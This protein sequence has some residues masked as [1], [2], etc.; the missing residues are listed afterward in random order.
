MRNNQINLELINYF[1]QQSINSS[2]LLFSA[3][4]RGNLKTVREILNNPYIDPN[5]QEV[6]DNIYYTP[7]IIA[8]QIGYLE[9]VKEL[10]KHPKIKQIK[11]KNCA[12][13]IVHACAQG[14]LEVVKE[15]LRHHDHEVTMGKYAEGTK[16]KYIYDIHHLSFALEA[17]V[18][19]NNPKNKKL[20]IAKQ[21]LKNPN[22]ELDLHTTDILFFACYQKDIEMVKE[23]LKQPEINPNW[24][25]SPIP[26][27]NP[28]LRAIDDNNLEI[29]KELLKH[30][31]INPNYS[32]DAYTPLIHAINDNNLEIV[33]EL[34]KHPKINPNWS[35]TVYTPLTHAIKDNNLVI[36]KELLKHPKINVNNVNIEKYA[37]LN[38]S[39]RKYIISYY[40]NDNKK[41]INTECKIIKE[42]LPYSNIIANNKILELLLK[43]ILTKHVIEDNND[44]NDLKSLAIYVAKYLINHKCTTIPPDLLLNVTDPNQKIKEKIK[45][46]IFKTKQEKQFSDVKIIIN[47]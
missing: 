25:S 7:L 26:I 4:E 11:T 20:E 8:C 2:S 28:L 24:S 6:K 36:V 39:I 34:L 10:L 32:Y 23:L 12:A 44:D 47:S 17:I 9:I 5:V 21:I 41:I 19:S 31:K 35:Y 40:S 27:L 1:K 30:P 16:E 38:I 37:S 42:L 13:P 14:H 33:K 18:K 3:C 29:V 46:L 43:H 15:L 45:N 22:R